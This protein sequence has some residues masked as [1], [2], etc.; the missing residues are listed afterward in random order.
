MGETD[1]NLVKISDGV[2][3]KTDELFSG[4]FGKRESGSDLADLY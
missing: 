3:K 4:A 2:V 1:R